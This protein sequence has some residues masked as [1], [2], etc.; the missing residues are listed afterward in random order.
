MAINDIWNTQYPS[1][2]SYWNEVQ[3]CLSSTLNRSQPHFKEE[4][5]CLAFSFP[6]LL[7]P[8]YQN[9]EADRTLIRWCPLQ[10]CW[11]VL[12]SAGAVL[13]DCGLCFCCLFTLKTL[14]DKGPFGTE[15][16]TERGEQDK[17]GTWSS[18]T[19]PTGGQNAQCTLLTYF[20]IILS[21]S[22]FS[23]SSNLWRMDSKKEK[24]KLM[25]CATWKG[26]ERRLDER[27]AEPEGDAHVHTH[28]GYGQRETCARTEAMGRQR[29]ERTGAIGVHTSLLISSVSLSMRKIRALLLDGPWRSLCSSGTSLFFSFLCSAKEKGRSVVRVKI[30]EKERK[31]IL[32]LGFP[33]V[34]F[35]SSR[36]W[37]LTQK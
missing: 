4:A 16:E 32:Y 29:C 35:R 14:Q 18:S 1:S 34:C 2:F 30:L 7:G 11:G 23:S 33:L 12:V 25:Y 19:E 20:A 5:G 37:E 28:E 27:R 10:L 21:V 15:S 36:N 31:V 22:L 13:L 8:E 9:A 24:W 26:K 6:Q 17:L 3:S